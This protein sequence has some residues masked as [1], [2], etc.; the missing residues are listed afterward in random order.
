VAV[1]KLSGAEATLGQEIEVEGINM[2]YF[3]L[4]LMQFKAI[5]FIKYSLAYLVEQ[6]GELQRKITCSMGNKYMKSAYLL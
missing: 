2:S 1:C 3:E 5:M 6:A 4:I